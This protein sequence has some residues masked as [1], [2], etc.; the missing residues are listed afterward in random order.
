MRPKNPLLFYHSILVFRGW[1][2][3]VGATTNGELVFEKDGSVSSFWLSDR[4]LDYGVGYVYVASVLDLEYL[5]ERGIKFEKEKVDTNLIYDLEKVSRLGVGF[6]PL[7]KRVRRFQRKWGGKWDYSFRRSFEGLG[8]IPRNDR[9]VFG[10]LDVIEPADL[11]GGKVFF[12]VGSLEDKIVQLDVFEWI[13][14]ETAVHIYTAYER[15][16]DDNLNLFFRWVAY[17]KL[18]EEKGYR[19]LNDGSP[20]NEGVSRFKGKFNPRVIDVY[21]LSFINR[22]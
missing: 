11:T 2:R 4:A 17:R 7:R 20:L 14:P 21:S 1:A 19:Y 18:F 22:R 6:K 5:E 12:G 8:R 15:G 9:D 3:K 13:R 16:L 10:V